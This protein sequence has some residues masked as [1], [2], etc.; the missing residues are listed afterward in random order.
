MPSNI[1]V[2]KSS[3]F[4]FR[5]LPFCRR[6]APWKSLSS[7]N[8]VVVIIAAHSEFFSPAHIIFFTDAKMVAH[9]METIYQNN[10]IGNS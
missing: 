9:I 3:V 6:G 4:V 7:D 10:T 1:D 5:F 8:E 2:V